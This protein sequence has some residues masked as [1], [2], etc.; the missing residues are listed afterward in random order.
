MLEDKKPG[1]NPIQKIARN[2]PPPVYRPIQTSSQPKATPAA[3][4][5]SAAPAVYRPISTASQRNAL[6]AA[7]VCPG[8][9]PVYRPSA[10]GSYSS[11]MRAGLQLGRGNNL[12]ASQDI[13]PGELSASD[14]NMRLSAA[15]FARAGFPALQVPIYRAASDVGQPRTWVLPTSEPTPAQKKATTHFSPSHVLQRATTSLGE[16]IGY[17]LNRRQLFL[18]H[19]ITAAIGRSNRHATTQ[20]SRNNTF[21]GSMHTYDDNGVHNFRYDQSLWDLTQEEWDWAKDAH[22]EYVTRTL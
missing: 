8:A 10:P 11:A 18:N 2:L 14:R 1:V 4:A 3:S 22:E 5:R 12:P 6:P 19:H 9:P 13:G 15:G 20:V 21:I 7:S 16:N 17:V